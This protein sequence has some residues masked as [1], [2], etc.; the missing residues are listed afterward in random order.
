M[1]FYTRPLV[2]ALLLSGCSSLTTTT[3]AIPDERIFEA[4]QDIK[5]QVSIYVW[6]QNSLYDKTGHYLASTKRECGN[7]LIDFDIKKVKLE[8]LT[9]FDNS[10]GLSAEI[11]ASPV[12]GVPAT[13]GGSLG[14]SA[15]RTNTQKL[16]YSSFPL[17]N[18]DYTYVPQAGDDP[19]PVAEVL[20]SLRKNLIEAANTKNRV[21]FQGS[22][23]D[24]DNSFQVAVTMVKSA[25]G[26]LV[27]A[28]APLTLTANGET[29]STTGNTITF[30]FAPHDFSVNPRSGNVQRT[31]AARFIE[32]AWSSG[33]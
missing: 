15:Q 27:F 24:G 16:V 30:T 1:A 26:K 19:A 18:P 12:G 33:E 29:K 21:C 31:A 4:L 9:T 3:T 11:A 14:A 5:R 23:A 6:R 8:L 10:G 7:G 22:D 32:M 28:L 25:S 2:I 20:T 17:P 13:L